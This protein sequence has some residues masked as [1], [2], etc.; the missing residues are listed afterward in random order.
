[1][2]FTTEYITILQPNK[3]LAFGSNVVG[4]INVMV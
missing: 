1:M 3:V 2:N 4:V